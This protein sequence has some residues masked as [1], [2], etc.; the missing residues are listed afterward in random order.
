MEQQRSR[1]GHDAMGGSGAPQAA[2]AGLGHAAGAWQAQRGSSRAGSIASDYEGHTGHRPVMR[3]P[4]PFL[5]AGPRPLPN[6]YANFGQPATQFTGAAVA[7][8]CTAVGGYHSTGY[9]GVGAAQHTPQP[10][11]AFASAPL[12]PAHPAGSGRG[13]TPVMTAVD[14]ARR[15]V[16]AR[17][18]WQQQQQMQVQ[19][20]QQQ[21]QQMQ[22]ALYPLD[23]PAGYR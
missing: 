16:D 20:Q 4:P 11:Y 1:S 17:Q 7:D 9:F 14:W 22:Q 3:S 6:P 23:P 10:P 15:A 19:M 8:H 5:A 21:R 13:D 2:E 18:A 12:P